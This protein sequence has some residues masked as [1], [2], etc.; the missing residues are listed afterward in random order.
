MECD[1]TSCVAAHALCVS[2]DL[3]TRICTHSSCVFFHACVS[4][5]EKKIGYAVVVGTHMEAWL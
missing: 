5:I 2:T 4:V 3:L 1:R